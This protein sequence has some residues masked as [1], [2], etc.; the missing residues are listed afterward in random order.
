[1]VEERKQEEENATEGKGPPGGV[2]TSRTTGDAG[3]RGT[4]KEVT[5]LEPRWNHEGTVMGP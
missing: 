1:L 2:T 3:P 5:A 4:T